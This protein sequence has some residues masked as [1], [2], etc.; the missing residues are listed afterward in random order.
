MECI[1]LVLRNKTEL[2]FDCFGVLSTEKKELL[3]FSVRVNIFKELNSHTTT[4]GIL[5][6]PL[7][8]SFENYIIKDKNIYTIPAYLLKEIIEKHNKEEKNGA[9]S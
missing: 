2:G 1:D 7:S 3:N 8:Y 9:N 5:F 6:S 4:K